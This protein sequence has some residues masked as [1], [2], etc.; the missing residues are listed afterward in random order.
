MHFVK[1]LGAVAATG[2]VSV[3]LLKLLVAAASPLLGMLFGVLMMSLKIGLFVAAGF[4][5]YR[6]IRKRRDEM[7]A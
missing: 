2:A 1:T 3:L 7:A 4:F 5:I 6:M